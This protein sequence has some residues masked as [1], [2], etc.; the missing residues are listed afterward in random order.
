MSGTETMHGPYPH[1]RK[2]RVVFK[3]EGSARYETFAS[4]P[5]AE[6]AMHAYRKAQGRDGLRLLALTADELPADPAWVYFLLSD[7]DV[8]LYVGCTADLVS[9]RSAHRDNGREFY[10]MTYLPRMAREAALALEATLI[11]ELSPLWNVIHNGNNSRNDLDLDV[12]K[13]GLSP[14]SVPV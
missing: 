14:D 1:G 3:G 10:R 12:S 6:C 13:G 5:E 2:W 4:E 7:T 8:V 9:R 11:R